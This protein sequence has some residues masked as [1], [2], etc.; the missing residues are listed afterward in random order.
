[1]VRLRFRLQEWTYDYYCRIYGVYNFPNFQG[2]LLTID[3]PRIDPTSPSCLSNISGIA[4]SSSKS[5]LTVL[6]GML[7]FNRTYQ[8]M[9]R[10]T[11]RRNASNQAT[12]YSLVRVDDTDPT[13]VLVALV[14]SCI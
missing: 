10:M 7:T 5:S 1:M 14:V 4:F 11:N 3:D 8:F 12:G 9:V 6:A 13:R 2:L